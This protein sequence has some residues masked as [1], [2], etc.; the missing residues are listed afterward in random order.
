MYCLTVLY[1]QPTDPAA[2]D[3]YYFGTHTPIAKKMKGLTGFTVSKLDSS[4]E[5]EP[6]PYYL[7]AKLYAE[8]RDALLAIF[9]SPE[10]QAA[11]ADLP[12]FVTGGATFLYGEE[13]VV[14]SL[15]LD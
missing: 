3:D 8:S 10:G 5:G 11:V 1:G 14:Y 2:F 13:Q 7:V 6:P 9:G 12:N 4:P 15:K